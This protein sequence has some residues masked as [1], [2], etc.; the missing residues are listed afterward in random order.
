MGIIFVYITN[1][2]KAVARRVAKQLLRKK[3][4]AC[5]NIY[6]GVNSIYPWKGT[7]ADEQEVIL[8]AKT[9]NGL[10]GAVR[11]EVERV[12]PYTVPCVIKIAVTANS[13]YAHW[14]T[15]EVRTRI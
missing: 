1:P 10:W 3:L 11:K 4:I 14:L 9:T 15:S 5:A 2:T 8:I 6:P 12:H 7:I 13:G